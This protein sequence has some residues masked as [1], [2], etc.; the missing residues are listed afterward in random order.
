MQ[1]FFG[2]ERMLAAACAGSLASFALKLHDTLRPGIPQSQVL[3][4][5]HVPFFAHMIT[6][7]WIALLVWLASGRFAPRLRPFAGW[8]VAGTMAGALATGLLQWHFPN[9]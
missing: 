2:V 6:V 4:S 3:E 1:A 8:L 9:Y 7:G 5:R